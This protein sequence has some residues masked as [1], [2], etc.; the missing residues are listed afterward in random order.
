M[1]HMGF[2]DKF[3]LIKE[4]EPSHLPEELTQLIQ[5]RAHNQALKQEALTAPIHLVPL[6]YSVYRII[7]TARKGGEIT[8]GELGSA[9]GEVISTAAMSA[10]MYSAHKHHNAKESTKLYESQYDEP[11][12]PVAKAAHLPTYMRK[13]ALNEAVSWSSVAFLGGMIAS[14][15]GRRALDHNDTRDLHNLIREVDQ[16]LPTL[17]MVRCLDLITSTVIGGIAFVQSKSVAE[18]E[19]MTKVNEAR[20]DIS[21]AK[22]LQEEKQNKAA[23]Q[24]AGQIGDFS[25]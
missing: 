10:L 14:M 16:K 3:R 9:A 12:T 22:R 13:E 18:H 4:E 17:P 24:D 6:A 11:P 7:D 5:K 8:G 20:V 15:I 21:H 23:A 2:K 25:P 19:A 1:R